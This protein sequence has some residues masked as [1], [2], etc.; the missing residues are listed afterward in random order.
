MCWQ[1]VYTHLSD[2][3]LQGKMNK[4]RR[5]IVN[6][7]FNV[8][9]QDGSGQVDMNDMIKI[10]DV[11]H[12]PEYKSGKKTR[13]QVLRELI[14]VFDVGGEKDGIVT[15]QEF[16]AYYQQISAGIDN[17]NMFELMVR[18]A[19]HISGGVGQAANTANRRVLVM[20][21][22]GSQYVEEIKSDLGLGAKDR[23]GAIARLKRQGV[24][25]SNI[26]FNGGME[27]KNQ[28]YRPG[29]AAPTVG[30]GSAG[31]A[32]PRTATGAYAGAGAGAGGSLAR[33]RTTNNIAAM[34][35]PGGGDQSLPPG[36]D[37]ED[38]GDDMHPLLRKFK[39]RVIARGCGGIIGLQRK[40]KIMDDDGSKSL[41][42]AEFKKAMKETVPEFSD[43]DVS[44]LFRLF[45]SF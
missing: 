2:W 20:R 3:Q 27:D 5:D 37:E 11:T 33:G 7:A 12:H 14:D 36:G 19:W 16:Q 38:G 21:A 23:D 1:S 25:A 34:G 18:N 29:S 15:R 9:D 24:D 28:R 10:Y 32:M 39:E 4:Q 41:N 6:L 30:R 31:G 45:G 44:T 26:E 43:T 8:L 13:E 35:Y 22:D 17:D 40:F 42:M